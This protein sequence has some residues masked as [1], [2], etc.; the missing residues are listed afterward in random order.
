LHIPIHQYI[1]RSHRSHVNP[2]FQIFTYFSFSIPLLNEKS[3]VCRV[4]VEINDKKIL[5]KIQERTKAQETY[6]DSIASGKGA[7]LFEIAADGS[8]NMNLGN[9]PPGN[10]AKGIIL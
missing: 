3:S 8:I 5:G 9:F 2:Q 1:F 7:Y 6:D 10:D 4:I